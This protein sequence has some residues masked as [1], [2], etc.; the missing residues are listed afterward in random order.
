MIRASFVAVRPSSFLLG[1]AASY[2]DGKRLCWI[3]R[4]RWGVRLHAWRMPSFACK[5]YY[6]TE[7]VGWTCVVRRD[8]ADRGRDLMGVLAQYE[9]FVKPAYDQYIHSV[10]CA[11]VTT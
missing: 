8:T 2:Y 5:R 9:R 6:L 1:C 4:L 11:I 7:M 10:R 3:V